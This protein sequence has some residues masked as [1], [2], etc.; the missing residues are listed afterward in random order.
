[1][2]RKMWILLLVFLLGL[3]ESAP[4]QA[5]NNLFRPE[6]YWATDGH[7]II[8]FTLDKRVKVLYE[9]QQDQAAFEVKGWRLGRDQA[10]LWLSNNQVAIAES[11]TIRFAPLQQ[12]FP[13]AFVPHR[14]T[15]RAPY[16]LARG[17]DDGQ[18]LVFVL[19]ME[20]GDLQ[21]LTGGLKY[22]ADIR[23]LDDG[24]T[25]RYFSVPD[26]V[27]YA[28]FGEPV[29]G[30]LLERDLQ[31]GREIVLAKAPESVA[32]AY[33]SRDGEQWWIPD[34]KWGRSPDSVP[35]TYTDV[36]TVGPVD[37]TYTEWLH[38][39]FTHIKDDALLRLENCLSQCIYQVHFLDGY[40][41]F[42]FM[43]PTP[44]DSPIL[45]LIGRTSDG[46]VLVRSTGGLWAIS[47]QHVLFLGDPDN[48]YFDVSPDGR[49]VILTDWATDPPTYR[50][51]DMTNQSLAF[52][53]E[54]GWNATQFNPSLF[55]FV[56]FDPDGVLI[57]APGLTTF[58]GGHTR[59]RYDLAPYLMSG[60]LIE[61]PDDEKY[62]YTESRAEDGILR[63]NV[64]DSSTQ[65]S[66]LVMY[67]YTGIYL[68]PFRE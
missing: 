60:E 23:F 2:W 46:G 35:Y 42:S 9:N 16:V 45:R 22:Y 29:A 63:I 14:V 50:L 62:L 64:Y 5:H 8:A 15:Y 47:P 21:Q 53:S 10:L 19:N 67:G 44:Q 68:Q 6:W 57:W 49:W 65:T 28:E 34:G 3:F 12:D 61:I 39:A 11:D 24:H 17:Y 55:F 52:E 7:H 30:T 58:Y 31:T 51:W 4:S 48:Y 40:D 59:T 18:P 26:Y 25:L 56:L 20:S 32:I 54:V 1:M 27:R 41:S 43:L 66:T 13:A 36:I 33:G 38:S 37:P